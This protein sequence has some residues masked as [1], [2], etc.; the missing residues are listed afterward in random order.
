MDRAAQIGFE[1]Q[2]PWCNKLLTGEKRIETRSYPPPA[3]LVVGQRVLLLESRV[4]GG[5][6]LEEWRITGSV[7]F[8]EVFFCG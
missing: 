7:V 1:V 2:A 6:P 3:E 8:G 5:Q 4:G